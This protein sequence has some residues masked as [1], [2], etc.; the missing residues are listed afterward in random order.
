MKRFSL[1]LNEKQMSKINRRYSHSMCHGERR[2]KRRT[3]RKK[4]NRPDFSLSLVTD[5]SNH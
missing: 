1:S 4:S 2:K 5:N 3:R